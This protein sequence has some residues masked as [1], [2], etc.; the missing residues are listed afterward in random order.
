MIPKKREK[1]ERGEQQNEM[2]WFEDERITKNLCDIICDSQ[3]SLY[4]SVFFL[5]FEIII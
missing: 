4:E 3:F 2:K 1:S 5:I